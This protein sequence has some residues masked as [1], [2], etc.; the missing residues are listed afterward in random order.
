MPS[1]LVIGNGF[2]PDAKCMKP[3]ETFSGDVFSDPIHM[4]ADAAIAY[5]TFTP[6]A[7]THWYGEMIKVVAGS[8]WICDK[9]G[10]PRRLKTG[11]VVW[12]PAGNAHWHRADDSSIMT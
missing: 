3:T 10:V 11:D 6:C 9:G 12:A 7:R 4:G 1:H 5:V 2:N 8:G